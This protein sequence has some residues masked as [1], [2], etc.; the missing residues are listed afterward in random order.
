MNLIVLFV[1]IA[2]VSFWLVPFL[3]AKKGNVFVWAIAFAPFT[4]FAYWNSIWRAYD[5]PPFY[6]AL[7]FAVIS[8]SLGALFI[9]EKRRDKAKKNP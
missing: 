3:Y 2:F 4:A 5:L 1:S 8:L 9:W 7:E 6:Y